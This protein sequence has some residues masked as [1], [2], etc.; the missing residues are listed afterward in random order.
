MANGRYGAG[1]GGSTGTSAFAAGGDK[2]PGT[3]SDT[4]EYNQTSDV[5]TAAAWSSTPS[6]GTARYTLA[7]SGTE[8]ATLA[9]GGGTTTTVY[10]QT[11]EFNGYRFSACLKTEFNNDVASQLNVRVIENKKFKCITLVLDLI[12]SEESFRYLNR[13]LLYE[14]DHK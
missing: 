7:G 10:G 8:T 5:I 6:L 3:I 13:K 11:E 2:N 1:E 9:S 12:I 14:L 4:E